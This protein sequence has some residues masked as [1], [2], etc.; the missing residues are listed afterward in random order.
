VIE[1]YELPEGEYTYGGVGTEWGA[2]YAPW[3]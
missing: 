1:Q 2:V 3:N